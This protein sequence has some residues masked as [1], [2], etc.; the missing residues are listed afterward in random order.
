MPSVSDVL[1]IIETFA[2]SRWAFLFDKV[3]LQVGRKNSEIQIAVVSL[4]WSDELLQFAKSVQANLI[5]CHHPI[6]WEPLTELTAKSRSSEMALRL[7]EC[8]IAMIASHTNW[9]SAPGGINDSLAILLDLKD[10]TRFGSAAEGTEDLPH[11]PEMPAGRLGELNREVR[12][13]EFVANTESRL[14]TKCWAWGDPDRMVCKVAVV[15][16]GAD[17]EWPKALDAGADVFLTGEVKQDRALDA[18]ASGL[19]VV[20]AGHHATEQ[21]GMAAFRNKITD[22]M[23]EIEWHLFV[24]KPGT[25]G[26]PL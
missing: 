17:S 23:P 3:G 11:F 7:A 8:G 2:P 14:E 21:P 10:V 6:I 5:I 24:P 4:D 1:E 19:C 25:S 20:A 22:L 26:R 16:G 12:F 9:D 18:V 13:S 15:G